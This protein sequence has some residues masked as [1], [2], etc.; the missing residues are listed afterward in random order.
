MTITSRGYTPERDL[1]RVQ[2]FLFEIHKETGTFQNW[3][4]TRFENSHLGRIEDTR[5]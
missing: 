5:V 4:P 3:L 2:E 1:P